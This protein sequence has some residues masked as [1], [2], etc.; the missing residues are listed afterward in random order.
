MAYYGGR[1][2]PWFG[3]D[4]VDNFCRRLARKGGSRMTTLTKQKTPVD[5][6]ALRESIKEKK[7]TIHLDARGRRVYATGC[8]TDKEY[9]PPIEHGWGI[10]GP[11]MQPYEIRPKDPDGWLHWKD[12]ATGQD[13]FAKRVMHPGSK[14]AHMFLKAAE[15]CDAELH[16]MARDLLERW[17]KETERQNRSDWRLG[18]R[19]RL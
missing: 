10:W 13:R 16:E 14:G 9:G 18:G 4:P 2:K 3:T 7:L 17:K 5:T 15:A 12:P 1:L 19:G 8:E 6:G 11:R